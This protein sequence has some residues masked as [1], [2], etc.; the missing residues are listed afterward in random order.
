MKYTWILGVALAA[1]IGSASLSAKA[2]DRATE[3]A[4]KHAEKQ[5]G[6]KG[7]KGKAGKE[8]QIGRASCRERVFRTV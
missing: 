7:E 8:K 2:P 1:I 3:P 5:A 6:K 4:R